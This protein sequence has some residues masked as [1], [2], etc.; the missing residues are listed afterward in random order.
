MKVSVTDIAHA[1]QDLLSERRTREE[2]AEW[3]SAL[4]TAEDAGVVEYVPAAAEEKIWRGLE[5]L[6]GVDLRDAPD[7][8]LHTPEDFQRF[9]N[10]W[11]A[12]SVED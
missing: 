1:L 2:I 11:H 5:F 12:L 4:R 9:A 6:I 8:Y 7:S 10:E 3:A